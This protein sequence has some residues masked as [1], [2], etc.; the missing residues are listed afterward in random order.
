MY[1]RPDPARGLT[2][3]G[4]RSVVRCRAHT[5][6]INPAGAGAEKQQQRCGLRHNGHAWR[7]VQRATGDPRG[8][9]DRRL[10]SEEDRSAGSEDSPERDAARSE[11][12][13]RRINTAS[14][15]RLTSPPK[16]RVGPTI[17]AET[18][19][20]SKNVQIQRRRSIVRQPRVLI[21]Q[22]PVQSSHLGP[23]WY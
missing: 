20:T 1:R 9:A 8:S 6:S 21:R 13:S 23:Q 15:D 19:R 12:R 22:F 4:A 17:D 2:D 5:S 18:T 16:A 11:M 7:I 3:S 10:T 14:S